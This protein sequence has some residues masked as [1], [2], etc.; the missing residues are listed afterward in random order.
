[1][2]RGVNASTYT[3]QMQDHLSTFE[4]RQPVLD[5]TGLDGTVMRSPQSHFLD[6][7]LDG[8]SLL[9]R[10]EESDG[11][12]VTPLNRAWLPTVPDALD[13]LRGNRPSPGLAE[14]RVALLVCGTCGDLGCGALTARLS[15]T[16]ESVTWFDFLWEDGLRPASATSLDAPQVFE[17]RRSDYDAALRDAYE[18]VAAL[19]YDEQV[20]RGRKFLWPWQWGWRLP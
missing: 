4:L 15:V 12:L 17:F 19:P 20:H 8:E 16:A 13:E 3:S 11:S 14:G 7:V 10:L 9:D 6:F 2:G 1:M 18:R 5:G